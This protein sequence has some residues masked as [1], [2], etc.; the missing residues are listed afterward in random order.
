MYFQYIN[1]QL[2]QF[3]YW[4]WNK[5]NTKKLIV[6]KPILFKIKIW[7]IKLKVKIY[8]LIIYLLI[9]IIYIKNNLY[10]FIFFI[11]KSVM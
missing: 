9:I 8:S 5:N 4:F 6:K 1:L 3:F 10:N 7:Y 11:L 2:Q